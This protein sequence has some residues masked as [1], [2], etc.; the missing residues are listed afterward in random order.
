MLQQKT[1]KEKIIAITPGEFHRINESILVFAKESSNNNLTKVFIK[2]KSKDNLASEVFILANKAY[3]EGA[4]EETMQMNDG[5]IYFF[6]ESD[7]FSKLSFEIM[8]LKVSLES[9]KRNKNAEGLNALSSSNI[10]WILS[11]CALTLISIFLAVPLSTINPREGRYKRVLPA[12]LIF[13]LYLGL[14]IASRGASLLSSLNQIN[15][16]VLIHLLF[17]LLA[18][19]FYQRT[20]FKT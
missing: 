1:L 12:L 9:N 2:N 19:Y 17:V 11:L 3:A 15:S 14:L 20:K 7:N 4:E 18:I 10:S 6:E 8:N 13:S 16:M 5:N